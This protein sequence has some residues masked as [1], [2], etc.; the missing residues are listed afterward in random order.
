MFISLV[1][2]GVLGLVV[3]LVDTLITPL[4]L[5]YTVDMQLWA[6]YYNSQYAIFKWDIQPDLLFKPEIEA[7]DI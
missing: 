7:Y 6:S 4:L 2:I 1:V 5:T 3:Y